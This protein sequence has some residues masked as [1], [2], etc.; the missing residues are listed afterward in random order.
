MA[1]NIIEGRTW[2][3]QI[4]FL[5]DKL[6]SLKPDPNP[7]P[8]PPMIVE[9]RTLELWRAVIAECLAT[10]FYVFLVCGAYSPWTGKTLTPEGQL[11]IALVAG[12]AMAVLVH[13]FGQ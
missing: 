9:V 12:F 5:L 11:T 8:R 2:E 6:E 3:S 4:L 1:S 13:S 7:P 10:V